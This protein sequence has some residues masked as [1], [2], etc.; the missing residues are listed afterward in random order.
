MAKNIRTVVG[1]IVSDTIVSMGYEIDDIDY[2]KQGKDFVLT[3]Y[4]DSE[5]GIDIDDCEKVSRAVEPLIDEA[6]PIEENYFLCVSSVGLDKPLKTDR[7]LEKNTGCCVDVKLYRNVDGQKEFSGRIESFDSENI[8]I[9]ME[10]KKI[11]FPRKDIAK[12]VKHIDF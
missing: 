2:S 3:I 9:D 1:N 7:D 8:T 5:Q 12:L 10:D 11:S 6:D 4:I